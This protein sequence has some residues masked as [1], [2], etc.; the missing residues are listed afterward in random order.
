[1]LFLLLSCV[2]RAPYYTPEEAETMWVQD[3]SVEIVEEMPTALRV[4]FSS[5]TPGT[6]WVEF[7]GPDATLRASPTS[8]EG[9]THEAIVLGAAP[10]STVSMRAVVEVDGQ[11]HESLLF[12]GETGQL[13]V[14]VPQL[15]VTLNTFPDDDPTTLLLS[16]YVHDGDDVVMMAGLD[17]QAFW[18]V[19]QARDGAFGLGV[20]PEADGFTFNRMENA[21]N[22]SITGAVVRTDRWGRV[23]EEIDTPNAHH[24][25]A[26]PGGG[27]TYWLTSRVGQVNGIGS[28]IGDQVM[29][30]DAAGTREVL[31][32]FQ[33]L[34]VSVSGS[35]AVADWSHANW[36]GYTPQRGTLLL[37]AGFI[38]TLL[39]VSLD[40]EVLDII[41]GLGAI[42]G[43]YRTEPPE[44]AFVLPHGVHWTE[45]G[46]LLM[47]AADASGVVQA[48]RYSV[49]QDEKVLR[50]VWSHGA[51][52]G[53]EPTVLGEVQELDDGN[54]FVSWGGWGMM[55][56]LS[57]DGALLW[58]AYTEFLAVPGQSHVL[59]SPY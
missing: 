23:V 33:E 29:R 19:P 55:Q 26:R 15:D 16:M 45:D 49:D 28:V 18:A 32:L 8:S 20:L 57:P 40:G 50:R 43:S 17:G 53:R 27:E 39:E 41:N 46:D 3:I 30:T 37:S 9:T 51:S 10:L 36:L 42:N 31:D 38:N 48:M 5:T 14:A 12:S 59:S 52:L 21:A 56:I 34:E 2:E 11:R 25:F 54:I 47:F 58:E 35:D 24:F 13:P 7:G 44:D 6:A 1:M 22:G 4:Q